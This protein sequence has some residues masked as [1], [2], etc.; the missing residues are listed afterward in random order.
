MTCP[1]CRAENHARRR[2]CGQC[3]CNFAPACQACGFANEA[4]DRFCGG[5]GDALRAVGHARPA[6]GVALPGLPPVAVAAATPAGSPWQVG[7]LAG[8]FSFQPAVPD[9]GPKLPETGVGQDD[10]DRLFEAVP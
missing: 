1:G 6:A 2:Y 5:C 4:R 3:G 8:L 7:E 9:D 10:L